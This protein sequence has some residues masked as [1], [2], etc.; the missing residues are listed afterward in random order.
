MYAWIIILKYWVKNATSPTLQKN[1]I[2]PYSLV[3]R[4]RSLEMIPITNWDDCVE[5]L[6]LFIIQ[7]KYWSKYFYKFKWMP[8]KLTSS[9]AFVVTLLP[10]LD[11]NDLSF[12]IDSSVSSNWTVSLKNLGS[13]HNNIILHHE[14]STSSGYLNTTLLLRISLKD[15]ASC[16]LGTTTKETNSIYIYYLRGIL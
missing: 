8:S 12:A 13:Y 16:M 5:K 11:R 1:Q 9:T 10:L 6:K 15:M 3:K 14:D 4:R 2:L 7:D